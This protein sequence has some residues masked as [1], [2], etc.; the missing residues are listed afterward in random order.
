[1]VD[2]KFWILTFIWVWHDL[3][4][5]FSRP[6]GI[7]TTGTDKIKMKTLWLSLPAAAVDQIELRQK[8]MPQN[9]G[10]YSK[11]IFLINIKISYNSIKRYLVFHTKLVIVFSRQQIRRVLFNVPLELTKMFWIHNIHHYPSVVCLNY[12]SNSVEQNR[13]S[14]FSYTKPL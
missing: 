13:F 8:I 9:Y 6:D 14:L 3:S 12:F 1:M 11:L 10:L 5:L 7:E 4:Q 2:L